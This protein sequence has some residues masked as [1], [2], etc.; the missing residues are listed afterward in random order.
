MLQHLAAPVCLPPWQLA[1]FLSVT[2]YIRESNSIIIDTIRGSF[3]PCHWSSQFLPARR[4][5]A[6]IARHWSVSAS[7]TSVLSKRLDGS[8]WFWA[9]GYSTVDLSRPTL[10]HEEIQVSW[11]SLRNFV[12]NSAL[13]IL[14]GERPI[15][16]TQLN[17]HVRTQVLTPQCPHLF[18][19][20]AYE[21]THLL[22]HV[23]TMAD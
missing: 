6:A 13:W 23:L 20:T 8:S 18:N 14:G 12:R 9:L 19:T 7:V 15:P 21:T 16:L 10:C 1:R 11:I 2:S 17:E 4:R 3:A 5:A 22:L